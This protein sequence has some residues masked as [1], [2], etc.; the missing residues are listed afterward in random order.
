MAFDINGFNNVTSGAAASARHY[1]YK[2]TSD[3]LATCLADDYFL[4]LGSALAADDLVRVVASDGSGTFV[5]A[6]ASSS[7]VVMGSSEGLAHLRVTVSSAEMLALATT[8]K[9]L[10]PAPGSGKMALF[11]YAALQVDYNSAAY[12]FS[13]PGSPDDL[14]VRYT[15]GSGVIVSSTITASGFV[16]A[17][18]DTTTHAVALADAI[19]A[20]SAAENKAL[21]LDNTGGNYTTG[22]SPV[23]VDVYYRVVAGV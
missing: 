22:D 16:T 17:T 8:A 1:S 13:A 4:D 21:V 2:T 6:S 20:N 14:A 18:A 7:T 15:D 19:V 12:A 3:T 11:D 23:V 5:V 10:V 9:E